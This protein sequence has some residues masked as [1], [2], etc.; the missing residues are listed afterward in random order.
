MPF[1]RLF[2]VFILVVGFALG[3]AELVRQS[4]AQRPDQSASSRC[5]DAAGAPCANPGLARMD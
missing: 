1:S 5:D 4:D 2:I 3:F